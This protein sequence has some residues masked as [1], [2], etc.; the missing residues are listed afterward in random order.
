[1]PVFDNVIFCGE[2]DVPCVV[3]PGR[4]KGF[5]I[6]NDATGAGAGGAIP[7]PE[8]KMVCG[9]VGELPVTVITPALLPIF[10]GE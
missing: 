7:V 10:A 4:L 5:A 6:L 3:V 9:L 1:M 2:M 8:R